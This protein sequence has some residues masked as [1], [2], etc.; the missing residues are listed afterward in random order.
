MHRHVDSGPLQ[1][2]RAANIK[3]KPASSAR[4]G[5]LAL[6]RASVGGPGVCTPVSGVKFL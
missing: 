3:Y 1:H 5:G 2:M 6:V 4:R